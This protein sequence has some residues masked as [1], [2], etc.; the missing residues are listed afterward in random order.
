[1]AS[2]AIASTS[3]AGELSIVTKD[4]LEVKSHDGA[5]K[6]IRLDL[7]GDRS[8]DG[9][10]NLFQGHYVAATPLGVEPPGLAPV[11]LFTGAVQADEAMRGG[12]SRME[13]SPILRSWA[14]I[15]ASKELNVVFI[16]ERLIAKAKFRLNTELNFRITPRW[17]FDKVYWLPGGE[18]FG[19]EKD[20]SFVTGWDGL[21]LT[22]PTSPERTGIFL[23]DGKTGMAYKILSLAP[24]DYWQA[25]VPVS[26]AGRE[27]SW[28]WGGEYTPM[29]REI[30]QGTQNVILPSVKPGQQFLSEYC[31]SIAPDASPSKAQELFDSEAFMIQAAKARASFDRTEAELAG[32]EEAWLST[33]KGFDPREETAN[34]KVK[35]V[36]A[37]VRLA[38]ME[39]IAANAKIRADLSGR[40]LEDAEA[41]KGCQTLASKSG[42]ELNAAV[43]KL[44]VAS[45]GIGAKFS[46]TKDIAIA[47][48]SF[49]K[50]SAELN[51]LLGRIAESAAS[52][53]ARF[54]QLGW[55]FPADAARPSG[56]LLDE[57]PIH[58]VCW[59]GAAT[60]P[61]NPTAE[62]RKM[63]A[64]GM[65]VIETGSHAYSVDVINLAADDND[66]STVDALLQPFR[67]T[68]MKAMMG[69]NNT[70][71]AQSPEAVKAMGVPDGILSPKSNA[72]GKPEIPDYENPAFGE[73]SRKSFRRLGEHLKRD[74]SDVIW[75]FDYNNEMTWCRNTTPFAK[76]NFLSYM[77]EKYGDIDRLNAAWGS[78]YASWEDLASAF[79]S[80]KELLD[81]KLGKQAKAEWSRYEGCVGYGRGFWKPVYDGLKAGFPEAVC[82]GRDPGTGIQ[83]AQT[84][85]SKMTD[86]AD[87]HWMLWGYWDMA[88]HLRAISGGKPFTNTE[89]WWAM[90]VEDHKLK[91]WFGDDVAKESARCRSSSMREE[92]RLGEGS[93]QMWDYFLNGCNGFWWFLWSDSGYAN[94]MVQGNGLL[95]RAISGV[96]PIIRES[97][98]LS[99]VIRKT[100]VDA[101]IAVLFS[102]SQLLSPPVLALQALNIQHDVLTEGQIMAGWLSRYKFLYIAQGEIIPEKV[103]RSIVDWVKDGGSLIAT[104][105][106]GA[107]N[108]LDK[109]SSVISDAF[110]VKYIAKRKLGGEL[111]LGSSS[112]LSLEQLPHPNP[113][114]RNQQ[115]FF[116]ACAA[117]NAGWTLE[118]DVKAKTIGNYENGDL[119]AV[120]IPC[121]KGKAILCGVPVE[122][123]L[124]EHALSGQRKGE[125]FNLAVTGALGAL[126]DMA[127]VR[128]DVK[129]DK[130]GEISPDSVQLFVRRNPDD[131]NHLYVFLL[132]IGHPI[133]NVGGNCWYSLPYLAEA[134]KVKL[135][136]VKPVKRAHELLRDIDLPSEISW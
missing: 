125:A 6:S 61:D 56:K 7:K 25:R 41:F 31:L 67:K 35:A 117:N 49:D 36:E 60:G 39:G 2:F 122:T 133:A 9:A 24:G 45:T 73:F 105:R 66:W 23:T 72:F 124:W 86:V 115:D 91:T 17:F 63:K 97:S 114:Q 4:G 5:L 132:N 80:V 90:W 88:A 30:C 11:N 78:S 53:E 71:Y 58:G 15:Y 129:I 33:A 113:G 21:C 44:N 102:N 118:A 38:N 85:Q 131:K 83:L 130:R 62:L 59:F 32:L 136:V 22:L 47:R 87:L 14:S 121:G 79:P 70:L 74:Y 126:F 68:G 119:A 134:Q 100:E 50:A 52:F 75:G 20:K 101:Q 18:A 93:I 96:A 3:F 54:K 1:M 135:S 103:S 127:G 123:L 116:K 98:F 55:I 13:G 120:E 84:P 19:G 64:L 109:E 108:E 28:E 110:G 48:S 111:R 92:L 43:D 107:F 29:F 8:F 77:K 57:E 46:E 51:D 128:E 37:Q 34:L 112:V 12:S 27:G 89:F 106:V 104:G 16:R 65:N 42:K 10:Q 99:P 26:K 40:E 76:T 94:G 95:P 82:V 81:G 69:M